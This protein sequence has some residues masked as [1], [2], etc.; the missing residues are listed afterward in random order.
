MGRA[1]NLSQMQLKLKMGSLGYLG[2]TYNHLVDIQSL[3]KYLTED[4]MLDTMMDLC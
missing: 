4:Y 2:K 1:G 3:H